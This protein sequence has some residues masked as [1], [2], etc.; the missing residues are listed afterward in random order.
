MTLE[1]IMFSEISQQ[2]K[3]NTPYNHLYV[4]SRKKL[5][6]VYTAKW[7]QTKIQRTN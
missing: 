3:T 5:M 7:K 6:N 4:E 1:S 2:K